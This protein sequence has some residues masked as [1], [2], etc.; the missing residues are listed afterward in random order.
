M[1]I[2]TPQEF[3]DRLRMRA[4]RAKVVVTAEMLEPLQEYFRLLTRWNGRINLTALPL[5][6]PTDETFDRLFIE[7]LAA[8]SYVQD[9]KA[10]W[11]DLGAGSGSPAIPLKIARPTLRLTM[12][13]SRARKAA[14]LREAVRMLALEHTTVEH[15]RFEEVAIRPDLAGTAGLVTVR[16]VRPD[17][18]LFSAAAQLLKP[19]GQLLLFRRSTDVPAAEGFDHF[20]TAVLL[21]TPVAILGMLRRVFHVEQSR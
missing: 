20:E 14:F 5:L 2:V 13:E 15:S 11:F 10:V 16:A 7:P 9:G 17:T 19:R 3:S 12:V 18:V 21:H 8:V 6:R 4:S 1:S